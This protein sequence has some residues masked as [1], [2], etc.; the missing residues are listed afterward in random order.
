MEP[1]Q[2]IYSWNVNDY[3]VRLFQEQDSLRY[4]TVDITSREILFKGSFDFK[5]M[6]TEKMVSCLKKCRVMIEDNGSAI[7]SQQYHT[8]NIDDKDIHLISGNDNLIWNIYC[9]ST[10]TSSFYNFQECTTASLRCHPETVAIIDKIKN[11][12]FKD[13]QQIFR[14]IDDFKVSVLSIEIYNE[15]YQKQKK[16]LENLQLSNYEYHAVKKVIVPSV[17]SSLFLSACVVTDLTAILAFQSSAAIALYGSG[18]IANIAAGSFVMCTGAAVLTPIIVPVS[19]AYAYAKWNYDADNDKREII[20]EKLK[21]TLP[22]TTI[23]VEIEPK[24]TAPSIIDPR[25][26]VSKFTWAVT[27]I[28]Y[29]GS[30]GNHAEI[31]IEGINDGFYNNQSPLIGTASHVKIGEK[32]FHLA[33]FQPRI[34]SGLLSPQDL[35]YETRTEIWMLTC[36]KVKT[37]IRNIETEKTLPHGQRFEYNKWGEGYKKGRKAHNCFTW[38]QHHLQPL[39]IEFKTKNQR[40]LVGSVASAVTD[41]TKKTECYTEQPIQG[42]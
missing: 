12:C 36:E 35:I 29:N 20:E 9:N 14:L 33:H 4:E 10:Q 25:V 39:G 24:I 13:F 41:Y 2:H 3:E 16:N 30:F 15:N 5:E 7:F 38:A 17:L 22:Q 31:A 32:F 40:S 34:E 21:K 27:V 26:I 1:I 42:I 28:T 18:A 8:W 19:A 37:M 23:I 11:E 6:T